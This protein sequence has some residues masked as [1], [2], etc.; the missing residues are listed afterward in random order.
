[1]EEGVHGSP[2]FLVAAPIHE[3]SH[4]RATHYP[5]IG[6]RKS[7]E[8]FETLGYSTSMGTPK[9]KKSSAVGGWCSPG[10]WRTNGTLP[11]FPPWL[12]RPGNALLQP[13]PDDASPW[14]A[15]PYED[16]RSLQGARAGEGW[17]A[18]VSEPPSLRPETS[19]PFPPP[20]PLANRLRRPPL[21]NR[22]RLR[23]EMVEGF[24]WVEMNETEVGPALLAGRALMG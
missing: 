5:W 16:G 18:H 21:A 22:L 1:M 15:P 12:T 2:Y 13:L 14:F 20:P 10:V 7:R 24:G 3:Q 9:Q 11:W 6:D 19:P 17:R 4:Q 8:N 23:S